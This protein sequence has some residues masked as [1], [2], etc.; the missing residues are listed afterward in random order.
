MQEKAQRRRALEMDL[1]QAI[2]RQELLLHYQPIISLDQAR[3]VGCEALIRW[4]HSERGLISPAE[5]IPLAEETGLINEI[6]AWALEEACRAAPT[7]PG[8]IRVAVNLSP[9]QFSGPDLAV[10]TAAALAKGGLAASRLVLEVTESLLL[11]E[12]PQTI[13]LLHR[14]RELGLHIALDDFGT[15]YSSLSLLKSFP[16]DK[17][18]ID[19][20]FVR[21]LPQRR[22]CE[23]IVGAV[24]KLAMSLDM[25][26]VA[27]G[28]ETEEHLARVKAA[29]CN[30][31]QGYLF[32]RPVPGDQIVD[33]VE[34][35]DAR[36]SKT[37]MAAA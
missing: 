13:G 1:G 15:G 24:A 14:L 35:I 2:A 7:W 9:A 36:L 22:N 27:E 29:G 32:S 10:I 5:F 3:V 8:D 18:K 26:T 37:A 34:A 31:V 28:V 11:G 4:R 23:A 6:G 30:Q 19:Q 21:D 16:F 25:T 20:S 17:I 33:V 12:D